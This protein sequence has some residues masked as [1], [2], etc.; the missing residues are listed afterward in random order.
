MNWL[1]RKRT[2]RWIP[3]KGSVVCYIVNTAGSCKSHDPDLGSQQCSNK[4]LCPSCSC[5]ETTSC[6]SSK[7]YTMPP[8]TPAFTGKGQSYDTN[9]LSQF[10]GPRERALICS[11]WFRDPCVGGEHHDKNTFSLQSENKEQTHTV[12]PFAHPVTWE[13]LFFGKCLWKF[14][15]LGIRSI[16][17]WDK[18]KQRHGKFH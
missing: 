8:R 4:M 16:Y 2:K 9:S 11:S 12:L 10:P 5:C 6:S 14:P 17:A 7:S 1:K 3:K 15:W 18:M 13:C